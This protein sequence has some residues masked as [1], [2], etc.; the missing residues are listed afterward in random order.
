MNRKKTQLFT[1]LKGFEEVMDLVKGPYK[2]IFRDDEVGNRRGHENFELLNYL[3]NE[4]ERLK[5][6]DDFFFRKIQLLKDNS[7]DEMVLRIEQN[8]TNTLKN[9][10]IESSLD[11][12]ST[13]NLKACRIFNQC[14]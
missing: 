6:L 1:E 12:K 3:E 8:R 7:Q 11:I 13:V 14:Y 5:K 9:K 2:D 10:I 4:Y